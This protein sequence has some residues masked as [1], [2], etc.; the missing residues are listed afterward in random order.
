MP[1]AFCPTCR[2][3]TLLGRG[4][5]CGFCDHAILAA[6]RPKSARRADAGRLCY[7][8]A[9]VFRAAYDDLYIGR[10]LSLRGCAAVLLERPD[11]TYATVDSCARAL[12][13]AWRYAGLPLRDRIAATIAASFR[14]GKNRDPEQRHAMRVRRGET[15]DRPL[16]GVVKTRPGKGRDEACRQRAQIGSDFCRQ[17]DP[18]RADEVAA[19]LADARRRRA[20][21]DGSVA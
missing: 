11:V 1:R 13:K 15:A 19:D 16:C 12:E 14:H 17:H 9:D 2:T 18:K 21:G 6:A 10:G 3:D 20:A 7:A 8:P 4:G 5:R